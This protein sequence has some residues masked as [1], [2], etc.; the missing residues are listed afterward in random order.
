MSPAR[1]PRAATSSP[2]SWEATANLDPLTEREVLG[3]IDGFAA[4]RTVL[5]ISHRQAPLELADQVVRLPLR[6]RGVQL[7]VDTW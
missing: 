6:D 1:F 4:G 3:A 5:L 7:H 2:P